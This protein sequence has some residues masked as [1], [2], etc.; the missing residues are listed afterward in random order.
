M[1]KG[2][3][4]YKTHDNAEVTCCFHFSECQLRHINHASMN[5]V[6]SIIGGQWW[7]SIWQIRWSPTRYW[8]SLKLMCCVMWRSVWL[9]ANQ[10]KLSWINDWIIQWKR[11]SYQRWW[12]IIDLW[13]TVL[14][15]KAPVITSSVIWIS[16][17]LMTNRGQLRWIDDWIIKW[18]RNRYHRWWKLVSLWVTIVAIKAP[19]ITSSHSFD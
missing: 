8:R 3:S 16:G 1:T 11:H 5:I 4:Y 15:I 14:A 10:G 7:H 18:R 13:V 19:V 6:N 12:K 9:L 2:H 17:W